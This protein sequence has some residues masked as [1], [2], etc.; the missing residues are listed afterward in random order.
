MKKNLENGHFHAGDQ[1]QR[2]NGLNC[3]SHRTMGLIKETLG[4]VK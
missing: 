3:N 4:P 1:S 2:M